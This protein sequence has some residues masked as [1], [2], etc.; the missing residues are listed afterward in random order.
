VWLFALYPIIALYSYN[1][2]ELYFFQ[3][4]KP[5][6]ISLIFSTVIFISLWL[7]LKNN[8]Q[9]NIS[10]VIFL[11]I[12]WN[13]GLL[14]T[15]VSKFTGMNHWQ[16]MPLLMLIYLHLMYF[17][18]KIK[19]RKILYNLN[20]VLFIPIALLIIFNAF[21][22]IPTEYNKYYELKK[23]YNTN[24]ASNA[25]L[26]GKD[27]PDI[28]L[29]L[30]D[31]YASFNTIKEEYNYNNDE[32]SD[33][34]KEKG[35]FV[36][37]NSDWRYYLTIWN[38]TSLLNMRYVTEYVGKQQYLNYMLKR[39]SMKGTDT[40]NVLNKINKY[41]IAQMFNHNK[42]TKYLK[43]KGYKIIVL[44]G[45]SQHYSTFSISNT[46]ISFSYQ[47]IKNDEGNSLF[48]DAYST[49]LI[50]QSI[51]S[52]FEYLIQNSQGFHKSYLGTKYVNNYLK[53]DI[54][55]IDGPKF[56]YSHIVCPHTPFVF[57]RDGNY[58]KNAPSPRSERVGKVVP[59]NNSVNKAY[60]DQYIYI[61]KEIKKTVTNIM[62]KSSKDP[63]II[64]MSDHGPRP[65]SQYLKDL[66]TAFNPLYAVYFPDKGYENLNDSINPINTFRLILNKY[67]NEN[68]KILEGKE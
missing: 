56:I 68:Y 57:D 12:F 36:A 59:K 33:F 52:P 47:D 4:I 46:D 41:E 3:A 25:N 23:E 11:L 43:E 7:I 51:I 34:L 39:D 62:N 64:L 1:I 48:L 30:L 13:Y 19:D 38:V 8:F 18:S 27:Y 53:K 49:E 42:L 60:L 20:I 31:E 29:I 21:T 24:S 28:Y 63:V 16:L 37:N 44:E 65:Q 35:F 17:I 67:F 66:T 58:V 5:M 9:A 54:H 61:T 10:T 22:I 14:Y 50:R 2:E 55:R 45:F 40:Y 6:I 15:L 32:F 26:V